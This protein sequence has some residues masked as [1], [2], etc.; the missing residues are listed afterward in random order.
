V[1][2]SVPALVAAIS[3][4]RLESPVALGAGVTTCML[5]L[6]PA[7]V[8]SPWARAAAAAAGAL[9]VAWL[10]FGPAPWDL[11]PGRDAE[12]LEPIASRIDRGLLDFADQ[13]VPLDPRDRPEMHGLVLLGL[14]AL[15]LA[16]GQAVAA[17]R[18][19]LAAALVV[20]GA[21]W[22]ATLVEHRGEL[23][24][25][26]LVLAAAVWLIV[27]ERA[28]A[29]R[30]AAASLLAGLAVVVLAVGTASSGTVSPDGVLD[31][32]DWNLYPPPGTPVG[33][34]YV[35][36]ANYGGIEFPEDPTTVLRIRAPE[37]AL[38]WRASTLDTFTDDRWIENLYPIALGRERDR[39]TT[40]PM[41]PDRAYDRSAWVRQLVRIEALRDAHLVGAGTPMSVDAPELG[42]LF[43]LEGGVTTAPGGVRRGQQYEVRSYVPRPSPLQ[44]RE[45]LP[46]YPPGAVRYVTLGRAGLPLYGEPRRR[47][48]V[49]HVLRDRG[50]ESLWPYR[51]LWRQA[52]RLAAEATSPYAATLAVERWLRAG[53]GFRYEERPLQARGIPPLAD[54]VTRTRAGYCQHFAGTM[55][56]MLRLLGVPAR[57]AVGFTSGTWKEGVWTVTDHQAHAWVEAWFAGW[58]W[59]TFDPTPGRGT[60]SATYTVAS[61]SA[62]ARAALGLPD[63][64]PVPDVGVRGGAVG[65]AVN[66]DGG[67]GGAWL[68]LVPV[69]AFG[70][71]V[72]AIGVAKSARRR[73]R[74]LTSD[75]RR[76]AS[77]ARAELADWLHD[78]GVEVAPRATARN[79]AD[80]VE[81][82]LGVSARA[83]AAAVT[84]ARYGPPGG[85]REAARDARRELR[86]VRRALRAALPPRRRLRGLLALQSLRRA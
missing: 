11:V 58:G 4:L 63:L 30:R 26:A 8:R 68:L 53:G 64:A 23:A 5:A 56:L 31:W 40:G 51:P 17:R 57:V 83:L 16:V 75:S 19:L 42:R 76:L 48:A 18:T 85:A 81:S 9:L 73:A 13:V 34:Q 3:V 15:L 44:L 6:A 37:R 74:Y 28:A 1:L 22:A 24:V 86:L 84:R 54:F 55:A 21:G 35:W 72:A 36:D 70:V 82:R 29:P 46:E 38:Y 80:V 2:V 78:Q 20:A 14:F 60:I 67:K 66:P 39:I 61:D 77:A 32:R 41:L 45:S 12:W 65:P 79:L 59:L 52:Q 33:I 10:A 47:A 43:H 49:D 27:L 69:A 7:L 50:Y 71:F 25:G 62:D